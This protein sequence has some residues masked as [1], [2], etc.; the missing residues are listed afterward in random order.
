LEGWETERS[1]LL[2]KNRPIDS[3]EVF[4]GSLKPRI[5]GVFEPLETSWMPWVTPQYGPFGFGVFYTLC[6]R[7]VS[8]LLVNKLCS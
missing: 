1:I 3:P 5:N 6:I 8:V 2:F 7:G 4:L